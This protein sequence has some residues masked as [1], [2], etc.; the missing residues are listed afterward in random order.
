M[1]DQP[2]DT[3]PPLHPSC[4]FPPTHRMTRLEIS[5]PPPPPLTTRACPMLPHPPTHRMTRPE[6]SMPPCAGQSLGMAASTS[7][8]VSGEA[9]VA[10][11]RYCARRKGEWSQWP[12][13]GTA[14]RGEGNGLSGWL[15]TLWL[16]KGRG[17]VHQWQVACFAHRRWIEKGDKAPKPSAPPPR[18]HLSPLP[19]PP[20]PAFPLLPCPSPPQPPPHLHDALH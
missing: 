2:R 14:L 17:L 19:P 18:R 3:P 7:G 15:Q 16:N 11:C 8:G 4:C 9:S 5:M 13:A 20:P 1:T 6:I 12:A 10:G